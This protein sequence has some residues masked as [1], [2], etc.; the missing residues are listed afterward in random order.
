MP[1]KIGNQESVKRWLNRVMTRRTRSEGTAKI[2]LWHLTKFCEWVNKT[3]DEL[4]IDR[5]TTIESQVL[6]VRRTHEDLLT[7]YFGHLESKRKLARNTALVAHA[8]IRSFYRANYVPLDVDTPES[9]SVRAERVPSRQ[10]LADVVHRLTSPLQKALILFSVQSGQRIGVIR[11]L[12]YAMVKDALAT[13]KASA[14]SVPATLRDASGVSVNKRRQTYDFFIG[15]QA[16]DALHEY[17][18]FRGDLRDADLVFVST[19]KHRGKPAP[20][21]DEQANRLIRRAFVETG[22]YTASEARLLHHHSLRKFYQTSMEQAGVAPTWYEQMMGHV[23]P[24]TQ[25]A[26]SKPS[27]E[28]L[29]AAYERAE[30][31]LSLGPQEPEQQPR[32]SA[33]ATQDV[34]NVAERAWEHGVDRGARGVENSLPRV[35]GRGIRDHGSAS[36]SV[37]VK[38]RV[39]NK[40]VKEEEVTVYLD[41]GWE[42][43]GQLPSGKIVVRKRSE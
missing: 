38:P 19:K 7:E 42:F 21:D 25:K 27:R 4:I 16:K 26:Y 17:F 30:P 3:P 40:V 11:S 2:Y 13:D 33:A 12:R 43:V 14:V 1:S 10:E 22:V 9:W 20:L 32:D 18:S 29:R 36:E 24:R 15:K 31:F 5:R 6:G 8:V 37:G 39:L 28:Q 35:A 23:L 41:D 34:S